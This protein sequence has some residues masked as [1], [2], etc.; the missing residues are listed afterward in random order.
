MADELQLPES[1]TKS[2]RISPATLLLGA[3]LL[4]AV[5]VSVWFLLKPPAR[6]PAFTQAVHS[7]NTPQEVQYADNIHVENVALSRAEN[8][9]HQ[10][11]TTLAGDVVNGGTQRVAT[12][13]LTIEFHDSMEQIV[14]RETR[15]L[16]GVKPTPLAP[17]ER[18]SFEIAFDN[19]P[20][21]W[22]MQTP[23]LRLGRL[24]LA[25]LK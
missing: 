19:V 12:L 3:I 5:G 11:V 17:G 14:L 23:T 8:F 10:E 24:Q 2:A 21:S 16:L 18:R 15:S 7:K 4:I 25:D 20:G 13:T 1:E 9:L 6:T 22:N